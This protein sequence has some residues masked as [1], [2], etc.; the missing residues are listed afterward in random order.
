MS[1]TDSETRTETTA[2]S[3]YGAHSAT[4]AAGDDAR[5]PDWGRCSAY[6]CPLAGTLKRGDRWVCYAHFD[7]DP[8]RNDEVTRVIRRHRAVWCATLDIRAWYGTD[9]WP[10]VY[11]AIC[12]RLCAAS[13]ADLMPGDIDCSP[14]R[15][16]RPIV[17]QWLARLERFLLD[18][19]DR[20]LRE[21]RHGPQTTLDVK[22]MPTSP[23]WVTH[24]RT[25]LGRMTQRLHPR[26]ATHHTREDVPPPRI[27]S[28]H[29]YGE[30][31]PIREPGCDD[32]PLPQEDRP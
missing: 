19:V 9:D 14:Y 2:H 30:G 27:P 21:T 17:Q 15:P 7:C 10:Q 24:M 11:R 3:A 12:L 22:A 23:E 20:E 5:G 32:E 6:G 31:E 16:G 1:D 18:A 26:A 28:P 8:G 25:I 29:I 4:G 13:R